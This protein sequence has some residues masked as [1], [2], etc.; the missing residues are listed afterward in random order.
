MLVEYPY[1][2]L[3]VLVGYKSPYMRKS[4]E[5]PICKH[6]IEPLLEY[7]QLLV[8]SLHSRSEMSKLL[9]IIAFWA[10]VILAVATLPVNGGVKGSLT[11][12]GGSV[13]AFSERSQGGKSVRRLRLDCQ[14]QDKF[15]NDVDYKCY[16]KSDINTCCKKSAE[17]SANH[18][19]SY[20]PAYYGQAADQIKGK[21]K[22]IESL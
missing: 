16:Y 3:Q 22:Y 15:G 10:T 1:Y 20:E 8:T 11:S 12:K 6:I 17:V 5:G 7:C 4:V 13:C 14:C 19:H 9:L 21:Q 18:Y 2:F